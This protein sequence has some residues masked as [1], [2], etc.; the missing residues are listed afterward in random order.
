MSEEWV[1]L[2]ARP[3]VQGQLLAGALEAE[4]IVVLIQRNGLGAIYGINTG[5]FPARL[6]V[7]PADLARA[8]ALLADLDEGG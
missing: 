4:G 3:L 2:T 6:L 8:R 5:A 1:L 7:R